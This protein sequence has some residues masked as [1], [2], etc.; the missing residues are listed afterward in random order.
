V[1]T[2]HRQAPSRVFVANDGATYRV[3]LGPVERREG[4]G[5]QEG[6][7]ALTFETIDGL[8]VGMAP[9][10]ANIPLEEFSLVELEELLRT[11]AEEG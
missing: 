6:L 2:E 10:Y 5:I 1:T 3:T 7:N 4:G 9:V 8:W 11:A